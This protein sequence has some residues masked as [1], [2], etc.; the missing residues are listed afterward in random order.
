VTCDFNGTITANGGTAVLQITAKP[1]NHFTVINYAAVDPI[2]STS[3]PVPTTC[4]AANTPA[5]CAAPVTSAVPV[6]VNGY[7]Y[8]D[9]NHNGARDAGEIAAGSPIRVKLTAR[10]GS[11]CDLPSPAKPALDVA[12]IAISP[13]SGA[14]SFTNVAQGDYCLLLQKSGSSTINDP[15]YP[16]GTVGTEN[17]T[18]VIQFT[19]SSGEVPLQNFGIYRGARLAGTVFADN[20]AGGSTANNGVKDGTEPG[21]AGI[22]VILTRDGAELARA[23]SSGDGSFVLWAP[24]VVVGPGTITPVLPG[25]YTATGGLPGSLFAGSYTRPS[26]NYTMSSGRN[27]SGI[28]F[29]MVAS[30]TLAPNGAQAAQPGN[31]VFYAHTYTAATGGQLTF[32]LA[33]AASPADSGWSQVIYQDSNCDAVL[34]TSEAVITASMAVTAGQ[35]VCLIVKQYVPAG[36]RPSPM[37]AVYV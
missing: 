22:T 2:G 16:S 31:A 3:P 4:T 1:T 36:A 32:T 7:A 10:N 19:V 20:G 33:N 25:G 27:D 26:V 37:N 5:G 8:G 15:G 11:V 9:L 21:L 18:G 35:K 28:A 29:G 23:V 13:G 17:G 6:T 24:S 34:Q 14:F 12:T 30:N